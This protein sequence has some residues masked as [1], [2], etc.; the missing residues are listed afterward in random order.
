MLLGDA[1]RAGLD[2]LNCFTV[3]PQ[4]PSA[5]L[6]AGALLMVVDRWHW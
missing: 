3:R 6:A 2:L 4:T 1:E 5:W